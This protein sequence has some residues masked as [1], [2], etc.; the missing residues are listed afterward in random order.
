MKKV[1]IID[2][3]KRILDIYLRI[4]SP[5]GVAVRGASNAQTATGILV[6]ENIDLVLLD[7]KMP[8]IDGKTMFEII[9]E[10]DPD[11]KVIVSSVYPIERQ[12]QLVPRAEDYYDKAE[13]PSKLL[14]KVKHMLAA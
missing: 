7:I 14:E 2:D 3:E 12:K 9:E 8:V 1:L 10:Y 13:G 5:A 4:L 6:S 11:I